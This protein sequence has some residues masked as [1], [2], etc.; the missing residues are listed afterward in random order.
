MNQKSCEE[1]GCIW[2]SQKRSDDIPVCY[3]DPKKVGYK[4]VNNA[5][6][7]E[8]GLELDLMIKQTAKSTFKNEKQIENLKFEVTYLT[9]RVLRFKIIDPK[10]SRYE[11]PIQKDF[12]LLQT[13]KK[14]E[15]KDRF[16]SLE[17][18]ESKDDFSF[19][20]IRKSSKPKCETNVFQL[21]S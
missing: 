13:V 15:E 18:S 2:D 19:S 16:Y 14:T 21:L 8:T 12:P 11:V 6:K 17:I 10:N 5:K 4:R 3:L 20:V 1:R 7:T 9:D